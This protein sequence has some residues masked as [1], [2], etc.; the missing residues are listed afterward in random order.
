MGEEFWDLVH[1]LDIDPHEFA[2]AYT[3]AAERSRRQGAG[4]LPVPHKALTDFASK[5]F[6]YL[7]V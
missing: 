2:T 6:I 7:E 4:E 3:E 5:G 1:R